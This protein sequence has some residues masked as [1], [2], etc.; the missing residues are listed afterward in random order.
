MGTPEGRLVKTLVKVQHLLANSGTLWLALSH[1]SPTPP[2]VNHGAQA[3][4]G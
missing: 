3:S 1:L 2:L 4:L